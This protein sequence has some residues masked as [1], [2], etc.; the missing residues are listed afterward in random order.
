MT[1]VALCAFFGNAFEYAAES[2]RLTHGH[3][4]GYLAAGLF[5]DILQRMADQ[6]VKLEHALTE[7][8]AV[9]GDKP[10]MEALRVALERVLF[11]FYEGYLP[12]PERI[13]E[14]GEGLDR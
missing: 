4:T 3:P 14:F 5:A 12:T 7:S 11:L 8:L 9:H 10:D 1:R 6:Q 2:G 13:D